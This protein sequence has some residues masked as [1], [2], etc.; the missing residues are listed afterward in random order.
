ME[1]VGEIVEIWGRRYLPK[2]KEKVMSIEEIRKRDKSVMRQDFNKALNKI[3][4]EMVEM[5]EMIEVIKT[6]DER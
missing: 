6:I 5:I 4:T 3:A 1:S 2:L